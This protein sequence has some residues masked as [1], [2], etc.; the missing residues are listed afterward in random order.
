MG[1]HYI[2]RI[3][4]CDLGSKTGSYYIHSNNGNSDTISL[5]NKVPGGYLQI[6]CSCWCYIHKREKDCIVHK[7]LGMSF[8]KYMECI[9]DSISEKQRNNV[10]NGGVNTKIEQSVN[11]VM[12]CTG[13]N[14]FLTLKDSTSESNFHDTVDNEASMDIYLPDK[15]HGHIKTLSGLD[16]L[17]SQY[18][19]S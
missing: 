17:N 16:H 6:V 14:N 19:K 7:C 8:T 12:D 9:I 10:H 18:Q 11:T 2:V 1:V 4:N 3:E 5:C 15:T 13:T